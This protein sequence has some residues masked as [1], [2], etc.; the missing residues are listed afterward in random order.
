MQVYNSLFTMDSYKEAG[1][2]KGNNAKRNPS[3]LQYVPAERTEI[4]KK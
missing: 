3:S 2:E 1:K 4:Y